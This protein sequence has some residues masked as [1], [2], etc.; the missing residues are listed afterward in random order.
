MEHALRLDVIERELD[1][2]VTAV[3]AGPLDARVPTCPD[4]S[5]DD[6]AKHVGEFCGFWTHVLCEGTSRPKTP[7]SEEVGSDGRVGWLTALAG[8]LVAE[9][10]ATA[11]DTKVWTWYDPDQSAAFVARRCSHELAIHR[12]DAQLA[13]GG[14]DPV[15][16][17]LAADGI[18][19]IFLMIGW[20]GQ[21]GRRGTPG[22]GQTLH[23]HGTDYDP[24]EWLISLD[25][26]RVR[27]SR[28]HAKADLGLRGAVSDLEMVL[29]QRPTVGSVER[30]GDPTVLE[31]FYGEF[32]FG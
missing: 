20:W 8:H 16:A 30:F 5:V 19:E 25:P 14:A 23:L 31:V 6:L 13:R 18:E 4:F 2:L 28:E 22:S 7:F 10:R 29:Y 3:A 21:E 26:D 17:E 15:E 27:V 1:A 9:L 24:A 11:P 32:T 12:V